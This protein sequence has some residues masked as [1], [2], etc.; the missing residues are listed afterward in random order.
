MLS[1]LQGACFVSCRC[2]VHGLLVL[3]LILHSCCVP[4]A[5]S[6]GCTA[7]ADCASYVDAYTSVL[8]CLGTVLHFCCCAD[9]VMVVQQPDDDVDDILADMDMAN[10]N[11]DEDIGM[12]ARARACA[13]FCL[14]FWV[15]WLLCESALMF[16]LRVASRICTRAR[17]PAHTVAHERGFLVGYE[18]WLGIDLIRPVYCVHVFRGI[19][20]YHSADAAPIDPPAQQPSRRSGPS[21]PSSSSH[22]RVGNPNRN[23]SGTAAKS[24][25]NSNTG[26]AHSTL[27]RHGTGSATSSRHQQQHPPQ[28]SMHSGNSSH[29]S[30]TNQAPQ[31]PLAHNPYKNTSQQVASHNPYDKRRQHQQPPKSSSQSVQ[32]ISPNVTHAC[33]SPD[34]SSHSSATSRSSSST[35][36]RR[37]NQNQDRRGTSTRG[38]SAP[39]KVARVGTAPVDV[40]HH[41]SSSSN[42]QSRTRTTDPHNHHDHDHHDQQQQQ[43]QQQNHDQ[44]SSGS[45]RKRDGV[46]K[47]G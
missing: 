29:S 21:S 19:T 39:A 23:G 17:K 12:N 30:H 27:P 6:H 20:V 15:F 22:R 47:Q 25:T 28:G 11:F 18:L 4:A 1:N 7:A 35:T 16:P 34:S 42:Q 13:F 41:G 3:C 33:T 32:H 31:Q 2:S 24:H 46:G 26:S 9:D 36:S 8:R 37:P 10:Y 38:E 40:S 5:I 44:Q 43:Q 14:G 45:K